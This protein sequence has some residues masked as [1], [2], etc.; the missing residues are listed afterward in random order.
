MKII[1]G[2]YTTAKI[3]T[4][5]V[6]DYA[7]A[8][9]K[10]LCDN[11][12]FRD[13]KIV[14]MPDIHPGK[15]STIGFTSTLHD[16]YKGIMPIIIG[17]DIGCGILA[18]KLK[19]KR[20]EPQKLDK[21]I[22]ENIPSGFNHHHSFDVLNQY[23]SIETYESKYVRVNN[24]ILLSF[25]TLGG[26]NHFIEIDKDPDDGCLWLLIHSGSRALGAAVC[27]TYL[28]IAHDKRPEVPYELGI[29][30][31][32][33]FNSYLIDCFRA[34][35]FAEQNRSAIA[36]IIIKK[37]KW[38]KSDIEIDIMH[39][40]LD[41]DS[42]DN[43]IIRKGAIPSHFNQSTVI[44][45][46]A[47]DG[48]IIGVGK[49]NSDWNYSAPHGAGRILNRANVKSTHTVSE[50]KKAMEGIYSPSINADTL[51]EAPF[52]YRSIEQ[53]IPLIKNTVEVLKILK[54]VYNFKA[55]SKEK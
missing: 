8:Q 46:N 9:I 30:Y 40:G 52:A 50:Y 32:I 43:V 4:D 19:E 28:D 21:V 49:G 16:R 11:P 12:A 1:E 48:V 14:C 35:D 39:N 20:F 2:S 42:D 37:M 38:H 7:I 15:V 55:G 23:C 6:E 33:D 5:D 17:T 29:I 31:D 47:K 54:P 45:I 18:I 51:D 10:N 3:M 53:I 26:G 41:I 36:N 27:N 22:R 25:G 24:N 34:V 44:P 13:E